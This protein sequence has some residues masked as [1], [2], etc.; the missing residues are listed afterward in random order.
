LVADEHLTSLT[1][2]D[3]ERVLDVACGDGKISA[4]I[5]DCLPR[6]RCRA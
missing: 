3:G 2:A 5:A 4:E 6:A 1:R